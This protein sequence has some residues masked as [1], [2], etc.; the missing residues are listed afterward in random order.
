[1]PAP[2]EIIP[3]L[4]GLVGFVQATTD[5]EGVEEIGQ[6]IEMCKLVM[7]SGSKRNLTTWVFAHQDDIDETANLIYTGAAY[8]HGLLYRTT[9]A[10]VDLMILTDNTSNTIDAAAAL[11]ADDMF[12]IELELAA[13]G[14]RF[15]SVVF[16]QG[17]YCATGITIGSDA[18]GGTSPAAND[19]DVF[20]L[21]R[22]A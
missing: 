3:S 18:Q 7:R 10:A 6:F 11:D 9:A 12:V 22:T 5:N 13:S 8:V 21:Y 1:M 20:I 15:G 4:E 2:H 14:Y 17:L 16:P 19:N